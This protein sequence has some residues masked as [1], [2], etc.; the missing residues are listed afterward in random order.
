[1]IDRTLRD[2]RILVVEDEYLLADELQTDLADAAAIVIGPLGTL[3]QAFELIK[4]GGKIDGAILDVNLCGELV[5]PA[6][7]LLLE[8]A[9]PFVFA[10]GY[11]D[12]VIP[13]RFAGVARCPKPVNIRQITQALGRDAD[14]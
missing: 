8:R 5:Y 7:D 12:S 14:K 3:D 9:V 6:A 10:T 2:C 4:A 1:M 11:D 13:S